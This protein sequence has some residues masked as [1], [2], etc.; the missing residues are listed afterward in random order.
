MDAAK[1]LDI[2]AGKAQ[3]I[4]RQQT[5]QSEQKNNADSLNNTSSLGDALAERGIINKQPSAE[6]YR[7]N[8]YV[9]RQEVIGMAVKIL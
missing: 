7:L 6:L 3:I 8:D 1:Y 9:L 2:L 4:S 5:Q